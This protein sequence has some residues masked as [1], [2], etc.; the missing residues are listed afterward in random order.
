M[1]MEM[2]I[3]KLR[4]Q[5][6]PCPRAS[7]EFWLIGIRNYSHGNPSGFDQ[8]FLHSTNCFEFLRQAILRPLYAAA[9]LWFQACSHLQ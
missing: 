3:F 9:G 7:W 1:L 4:K 6:I 5:S 8:N 2:R